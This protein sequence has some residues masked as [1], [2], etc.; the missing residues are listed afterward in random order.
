MNFLKNFHSN[1]VGFPYDSTRVSLNFITNSTG[2]TRGFLRILYDFHW[3]YFWSPQAFLRISL[4]LCTISLGF[5]YK[6]LRIY[7]GLSYGFLSFFRVV[8][9]YSPDDAVGLTASN[10]STR[11][12][13]AL[14]IP[15]LLPPLLFVFVFFLRRVR[16]SVE[17]SR[18]LCLLFFL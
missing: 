17:A 10:A 5:P 1:Y 15:P 7:L 12:G 2:L 9:V 13:P 8:L 11:A 4:D 14:P 3:I 18:L 6:F 16:P